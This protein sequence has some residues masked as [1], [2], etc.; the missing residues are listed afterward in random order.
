MKFFDAVKTCFVKYTNF[1][2]RAS[3]SEF[4]YFVLFTLIIDFILMFLDPMIAG[5]SFEEYSD[6]FAPLSRVFFIATF[7]PQ[8]SV[9]VRRLHD[10]NRSPW[11]MFPFPVLLLCGFFYHF[12]ETPDGLHLFFGP[13]S[14]LSLPFLVLLIFWCCQ[15]GNEEE[16]NFGPNPLS[17]E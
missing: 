2:D 6:P 16:N 10:V 8:L 14:L 13:L 5:V 11:W 12:G 4:W 17:K 9:L 1:S 15:R 3:R 7:I